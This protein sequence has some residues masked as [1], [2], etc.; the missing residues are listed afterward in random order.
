MSFFRD[1]A[2]RVGC[3]ASAVGVAETVPGIRSKE[4]QFAR[5]LLDTTPRD[6]FFGPIDGCQDFLE[7]TV[8]EGEVGSLDTQRHRPRGISGLTR[9]PGVERRAGHVTNGIKRVAEFKTQLRSSGGGKLSDEVFSD[10]IMA[11]PDAQPGVIVSLGDQAVAEAVRQEPPGCRVNRELH[12]VDELV[13][14]P[15]TQARRR[16]CEEVE[17]DAIGGGERIESAIERVR[18]SG[19]YFMQVWCP[20]QFGRHEGIAAAQSEETVGRLVIEL[21]SVSCGQLGC[22]RDRELGQSD[23]VHGPIATER[24][25]C[26]GDMGCKWFASQ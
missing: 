18:Q 22:L 3:L 14:D 25:Q 13:Q 20:Q 12:H 26:F 2:A 24:G 4:P 23:M 7:G 17:Q 9:R 10:E 5:V 15:R 21:P 6:R 11:Q 16:Q 8:L 19:G 1:V